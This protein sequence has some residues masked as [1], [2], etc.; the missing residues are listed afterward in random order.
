MTEADKKKIVMM[1]EYVYADCQFKA[2]N[3]VVGYTTVSIWANDK[4]YS[5]A[6]SPKYKVCMS[7]ADDY[8]YFMDKATGFFAR[9]AKDMKDPEFSP[10]GGEILDIEITTICSGTGRTNGKD[11]LCKFCY[12]SNTPCGV[13]MTFD[14][15]KTIIDKMS[16]TLTQIAFG[17]DSHA[18]SNPDLWKM[19][20]YSRSIDIVPNITIAEITD[21]VADKLAKYCGATAV[22]RYQ[23]KNI[24]YD[25]VK[26]LTDRGMTQINIHQLVAAE[27]YDQVMETIKDRMSDP[28]LSKLNAI[29]LLSLK[30]KG[31][32][33]NFT[34]LSEEK[35]K[36]IVDFSIENKIG[37]GFDS[38]SAPKFLN[39]V[40]DHKDFEHFKTISDSCESQRMSSYINVEGKYFPCSFAEDLKGWNNGLDVVNCKDF[41]N[42]I[43]YNNLA[44]E[45]R[46]K[47]I[48]SLHANCNVCCNCPIFEV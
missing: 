29:V 26:K 44:I 15:F 30:Q 7:L 16:K 3:K 25:S 47:L 46:N 28:R 41:L 27:T 38:C 34:R 2:R 48:C 17:A 8:N 11:Q 42:D 20:E 1:A 40:Q 35:F 32:G 31:R 13:N 4:K 6:E 43:W 22:S 18:E 36:S 12:K 37:I 14:T 23:D 39:A 33:V 10:I 5:I 21:E 45:F 19:M 9:W 24:C